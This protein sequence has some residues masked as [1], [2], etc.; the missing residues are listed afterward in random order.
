MRAQAV[1]RVSKTALL[2]LSVSALVAVLVGF[3][4]PPQADE[5][6]L[7]HIF[8]LSIVALMPAV[9][10]FLATSDWTQPLRSARPLAVAAAVLVFAF[11]ALYY[12]EHL[13]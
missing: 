13:R 12:L 11:G 5:G 1:N 2:V 3:T 9:A 10:L 6:A 4:Q 7:A 8:Q